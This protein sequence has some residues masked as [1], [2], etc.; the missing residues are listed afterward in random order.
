MMK[1][2]KSWARNWEPMRYCSERC[3]SRRGSTRLDREL[4]VAIEELLTKRGSSATIC[5]SGTAR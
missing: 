5:P 1:W 2:R 4:E 3:R